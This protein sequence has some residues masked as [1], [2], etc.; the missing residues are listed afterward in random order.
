MCP[1]QVTYPSFLV[2]S[3]ENKVIILCPS[4]LF[5][6]NNYQCFPNMSVN[7][8]ILIL[9]PNRGGGGGGASEQRGLLQ[10]LAFDGRRQGLF[11][12]GKMVVM[13]LLIISY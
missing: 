12:E 8:C 4:A 1:D 7:T 10:N 3:V 9:I 6:C 2:D 5:Q 11:R 13:W